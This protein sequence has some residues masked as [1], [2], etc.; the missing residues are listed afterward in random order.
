MTRTAWRSRSRMKSPF[1]IE[2]VQP[3]VP[4]VRDGSMALKVI[5]HRKEGYNE[6]IAV[7]LLNNPPG[8]GSSGAISIPAEQ[9][10]GII[11]LTANS[12]PAVGTW[13][14]VVVGPGGHRK[15][16]DRCRFAAGHAGNRGTVLHHGV[17]EVRG[18]A[19]ADGRRHRADH[20]EP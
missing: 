18:R 11:P 10:E 9:S 20:E 15:R 2:I 6:P 7:Y 19:G 4:I 8:I 16:R 17:R 5:A 1:D 3:Q 12:S 13:P 14:I